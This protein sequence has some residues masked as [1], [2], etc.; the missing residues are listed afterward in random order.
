M[1]GATNFGAN[2]Y[3]RVSV[4]TGVVA[5]SPHKL[6]VML[7]DGAMAAVSNALSNMKTGNIPA[8]GQAISKAIMIIENGLRASLDKTAGG[9][10]AENLDALYEYMVNRL[11]Q[12]NLKNQ[13][14]MLDEVYGLLKDLKEA[15]ESIN[16]AAPAAATTEP[17]PIAAPKPS[18]YD[19]LTPHSSAHLAKA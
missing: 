6:I 15:W 16:S 18:P 10:I 19:S 14:A 4:E 9:G 3:S 8:K 11:L 17:A 2:A 1:F 7:F 13:P 5:A 12:A